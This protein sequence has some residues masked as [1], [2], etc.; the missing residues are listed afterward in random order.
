MS[1]H[2]GR[3]TAFDLE[4]TSKHPHEARIVTGTVIGLGGGQG[5]EPRSW[6]ADPGVEIPDEAAKIHGITTEEA[7][8]K[9][10]PADEVVGEI[11][12][13]LFGSIASGTPIVGHNLSYD[14]T[15][16]DRECRRHGV[17][18]LVDRFEGTDVIRPVLDS[19]VLDKQV[20]PFR[21]RV[22]ETQGPRVLKTCA[23]TYDLPWDD[24]SA[25][26]CE[27]DALVSA[28]VVYRI[29][30]LAHMEREEWPERIKRVRKPGFHALRDLDLA[31]LHAAQ[32]TWA[33][34]QAAGL[35]AHFRKTDPESVV[36][37]RWPL[38]PWEA[39]S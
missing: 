28:R 21:K 11:A 26:G 4:T 7:H 14:F 19:M 37:G 23:Q 12:S 8:A 20:D 29:G 9:G 13:H 15:V 16:L 38:R 34:E 31:A 25:H 35:Q 1:W 39:T 18:P 22:S 36:D 24:E 3:M 6:L 17:V 2:L 32:V 27:Y 33:A 5:T 30:Q 10:R